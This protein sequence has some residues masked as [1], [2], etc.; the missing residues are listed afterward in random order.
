MKKVVLFLVFILVLPFSS[1]S[2]NGFYWS[3]LSSDYRYYQNTGDE[4]F[5]MVASAG[6]N[7]ADYPDP[8]N[9]NVFLSIPNDD[10]NP[11][12][13]G[14]RYSL[15]YDGTHFG[16]HE[17]FGGFTTPDPTDPFWEGDYYIWGDVN[18]NNAYDS[19]T[20]L[21]VQKTIPENALGQLSIVHGIQLSDGF[22]P[23]ISWDAIDPLTASNK[24]SYQV[25]I[26]EN[27]NGSIGS[28][29]FNSGNIAE[30]AGQ[31]IYSYQYSGSLFE[32]NSNVFVAI[33]A[34]EYIGDSN[35]RLNRSRIYFEHTP[36]PEPTTMFLLGTGLIGLA[37]ARRRKMNS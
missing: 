30:I 33:V 37:A 29:L 1:A 25:R 34:E 13:G 32:D 4:T 31:N 5:N 36:V 15:H 23:L 9:F 10:A 7:L 26:Y 8:P 28:F 3:W 35:T 24:V 12:A 2:A 27:N 16:G 20:D 14:T 18:N 19:G 6:F 22:N 11:S 17:F 21:V